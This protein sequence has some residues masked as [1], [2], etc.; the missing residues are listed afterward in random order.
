MNYQEHA[1]RVAQ[2]KIIRKK[3]MKLSGL[4][5]DYNLE[6][7]ERSYCINLILSSSGNAFNFWIHHKGDGILHVDHYNLEHVLSDVFR[8]EFDLIDKKLDDCLKAFK[9]YKK[10][11]D[12]KR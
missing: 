11:N 2:S 10:L 8:N 1:K 6:P 9:T 3:L 12:A 5:I 7:R 4:V